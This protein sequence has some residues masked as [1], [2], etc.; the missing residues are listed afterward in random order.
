MFAGTGIYLVSSTFLSV[1]TF[2]S[3]C[4]GVSQSPITGIS[5]FVR[6]GIL[7]FA[8]ADISL[9]ASTSS[10]TN[11]FPSAGTFLSAYI[12][13]FVVADTSRSANARAFWFADTNTFLSTGA[14]ASPSVDAF[15]SVSTSTSLF[16]GAD[17]FLSTGVSTSLSAGAGVSPSTGGASTPLFPSTSFYI[18]R[19]AFA[20]LR[21]LSL[22]T[23]SLRFFPVIAIIIKTKLELKNW[24]KIADLDRLNLSAHPL[25]TLSMNRIK[26]LD[27]PFIILKSFA[28]NYM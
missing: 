1:S 20:V 11:T 22:L 23:Y 21:L 28:I 24:L 13:L 14:S 26:L 8:S 27:N 25:A 12:S 16:I 15:L 7:L 10:S 5:R 6:A 19:S 17:V 3:V 18:P 9:F 4:T 2:P